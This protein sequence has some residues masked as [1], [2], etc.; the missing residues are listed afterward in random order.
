MSKEL[1]KRLDEIGV[2]LGTTNRSE[3]IRWMIQDV[4]HAILPA[5]QE[6]RIKRLEMELETVKLCTTAARSEITKSKMMVDSNSVVEDAL[7]AD[8][9]LTA[10]EKSFRQ[11]Y[12]QPRSTA[13]DMRSWVSTRRSRFAEEYPATISDEALYQRLEADLLMD[14]PDTRRK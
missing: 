12:I 14:V 13:D 4:Y 10:F 2:A 11:Y 5:M 6:A 9:E 3:I 7:P 8:R 1:S